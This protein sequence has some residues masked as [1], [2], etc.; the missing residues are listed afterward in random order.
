M[1][2]LETAN[3]TANLIGTVNATV[4]DAQERPE[5]AHPL[6]RRTGGTVNSSTM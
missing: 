2:G 6:A 5:G 3:E 4:F 1:E